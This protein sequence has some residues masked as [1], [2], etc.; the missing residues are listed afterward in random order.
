[1]EHEVQDQ[2]TVLETTR[3]VCPECL[4]TVDAWILRRDNR[5]FMREK[6]PVHGWFEALLNSDAEMCQ[7]SLPYNKPGTQPLGFST[8]V[9]D[10][11]P[12]DC[13]LCPDH[14][15]H[16]CLA[17][18]EVTS[19]CNLNCP[20]CFADSQPGFNLSLAQVERMLDRFVELEGHPEVV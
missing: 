7:A 13:G 18:I 4:S 19:D 5:V 11:C 6:C 3:S 10:G 8:R 1:M 16:T 12:R 17:L 15:Q 2:C 20:T 9:V 14:I